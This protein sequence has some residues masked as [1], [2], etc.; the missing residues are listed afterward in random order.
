MRSGERA[1]MPKRLLK[2]KSRQWLHG[3]GL[4]V[5]P[6]LVGY[7]LI[8]ENE[9]AAWGALLGAIIVPSIALGDN[10]GESARDKESYLE[11]YDKALVQN[12]SCE[13]CETRENGH[14]L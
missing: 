3:I 6:L 10:R 7:G 5:L 12:V 9:A 2:R 8:G 1:N 4:A 11:G 13:T 14:E